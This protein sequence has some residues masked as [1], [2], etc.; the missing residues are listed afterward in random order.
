MLMRKWAS[1]NGAEYAVGIIYGALDIVDQKYDNNEN[2]QL[3]KQIV[4]Q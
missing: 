1:Q 4:Y 2:S 3:F